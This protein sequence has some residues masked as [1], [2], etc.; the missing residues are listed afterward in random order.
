MS[1][2]VSVSITSAQCKGAE[3]SPKGLEIKA[4]TTAY[5]CICVLKRPLAVRLRLTGALV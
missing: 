5:S 3:N 1:A 2:K 4:H